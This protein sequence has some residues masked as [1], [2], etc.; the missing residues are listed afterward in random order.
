MNV[1]IK[2]N[3]STLDNYLLIVVAFL[4][5]IALTLAIATCS[6]IL[7]KKKLHIRF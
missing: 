5:T 3:V 7:V 4:A 6:F 2:V 1:K